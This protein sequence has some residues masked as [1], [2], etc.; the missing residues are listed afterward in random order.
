MSLLEGRGVSKTFGGVTALAAVDF[1]VR[2]GEIY[3]LIGPNGAGKTTL[4][5]VISGLIPRTA[6]DIRFAGRAIAGLPPHRIAA[7]GIARTFQ[8]VQ[9][10]QGLT[11]CENVAVGAIFA[12]RKPI[13]EALARA[14]EVLRRVELWP[15]RDSLATDITLGQQ[16]KLELARALA[17]EPRL[18]LLDESMAGLNLQEVGVSMDLVRA[19]RDSGVTVIIIEHVMKAIMGICDRVHVL[20]A[21]RTITV[22]PPRE[23][24]E[25]EKVIEAYLGERYSARSGRDGAGVRP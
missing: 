5:N 4:M 13:G 9:P 20:H 19:I 12:G 14:Q 11:V 8:V 2:E 25:H 6:G 16:K 21:G 17:M 10:L 1:Q 7:L 22:G 3:G 18:L 23:V 24:A 15:L